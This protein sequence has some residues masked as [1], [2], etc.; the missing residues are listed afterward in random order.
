MVELVVMLGCSL[1]TT[2]S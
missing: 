1:I 2:V